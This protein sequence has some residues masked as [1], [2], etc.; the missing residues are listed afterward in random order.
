M[1]PCD[2]Y[3]NSA[4]PSLQLASFSCFRLPEL[5]FLVRNFPSFDMPARL[6]PERFRDVRVES[7]PLHDS[8][9]SRMSMLSLLRLQCYKLIFSIAFMLTTDSARLLTRPSVMLE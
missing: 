8:L 1:R 3:F 9:S 6:F 7:L 5:L 4:S 2:S